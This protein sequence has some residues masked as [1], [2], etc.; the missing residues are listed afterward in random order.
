[1]KNLP[2]LWSYPAIIAIFSMLTLLLLLMFS[3]L[4]AAFAPLFELL[5][6]FIHFILHPPSGGCCPLFFFFL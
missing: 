3:A 5:A 1:M 2:R 6:P 4:Q